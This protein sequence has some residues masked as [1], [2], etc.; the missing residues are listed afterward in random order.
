MKQR[1]IFLGRRN[2]MAYKIKTK[3]EIA[4]SW[5]MKVDEV[6]WEFVNKIQKRKKTFA[7]KDEHGKV[8]DDYEEYF[9]GKDPRKTKYYKQNLKK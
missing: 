6:D 8:V 7:I 5:G 2:K 1:N 4:K 3:K 9:L